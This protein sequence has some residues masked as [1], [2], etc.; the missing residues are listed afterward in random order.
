[1]GAAAASAAAVQAVSLGLAVTRPYRCQKSGMPRRSAVQCAGEST[2]HFLFERLMVCEAHFGIAR[3]LRQL[4]F[5]PMSTGLL[6]AAA[7]VSMRPEL[8][9]A[10]DASLP[11]TVTDS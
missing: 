2:Y 7:H 11:Q 5:G 10:A 8:I 1:M 9:G 3:R 4:R 6:T